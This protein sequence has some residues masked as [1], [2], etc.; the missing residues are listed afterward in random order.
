MFTEENGISELTF[1]RKLSDLCQGYENY[2]IE[3]F[4][5][6]KSEMLLSN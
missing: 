5:N 4:R 6:R 1:T 2:E 3:T